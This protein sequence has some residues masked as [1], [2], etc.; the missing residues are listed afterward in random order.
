MNHFLLGSSA[1]AVA[2][3]LAS[4]KAELPDPV[5]AWPHLSL[6]LCCCAVLVLFAFRSDRRELSGE[7]ERERLY[8]NTRG[9]QKVTALKARERERA[10]Q[11]RAVAG[12]AVAQLSS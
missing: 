6:P 10:E 2:T 4:S 12:V 11:E 5:G 9:W 3:R 8:S 1:D 7:R